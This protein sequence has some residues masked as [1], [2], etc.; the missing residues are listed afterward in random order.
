MSTNKLNLANGEAYLLTDKLYRKYFSQIDVEEGF[1]L[2]SNN[3]TYFVDARYFGA[4][5][6]KLFNSHIRCELFENIKTIS[7]QLKKQNIKKLYLDFE[8]TTLSENETYKSF[9]VVLENGTPS[10][11]KVREIKSP[12][13]IENIKKACKIIEDAVNSATEICKKGITEKEVANFIKNK[14]IESGAE[15]LSFETIVAFGKNSAIPH[16]QTG[17]AVLQENQVI[18]IDAGCKVNGYCSDITRTFFFGKPDNQ[19]LNCYNAVEKANELAIENIKCEMPLK[20]GDKIARQFLEQKS[21]GEFFT[22]S[23]GHGVGLNVHE[24]PRLSKNAQGVFKNDMVFTIEPGV[25]LYG[26]FGIR[27]EDTVLLNNGIVERLFSD[28]K[29]LKII[30]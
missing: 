27:I 28:S 22:H 23:L 3:P 8:S 2:L 11:Q 14:I 7:A 9:G 10:L 1:L 25:Y 18:L 5:K 21:L 26:K 16:H 30:K 12:Q 17:S 6:E 19:F 13:E 20:D 4:V 29:E 15:D 24:Q